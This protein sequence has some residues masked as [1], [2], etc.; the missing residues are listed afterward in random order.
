MAVF[1]IDHI[2]EIG[3]PLIK[4]FE[5]LVLK[6]YL[7]SAMVPTIGYGSTFYM[8]GRRVSLADPPITKDQATQ[9]LKKS[10]LDIYL[11][12]VVNMCPTLDNRNK[13]AAILSWTYNLGV[14]ALRGSTMR[15]CILRKEWDKVPTEI[16]KWN[17]ASGKVSKGLVYRR[18]KEASLFQSKTG[19]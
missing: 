11:P 7:C 9:L 18:N 19:L 4:E 14:G 2:L 13:V 6:P 15:K 5:G 16:L 12:A 8:D 1:E 3:L 17:K 10:V